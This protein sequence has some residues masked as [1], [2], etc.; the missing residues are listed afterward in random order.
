MSIA[1]QDLEQIVFRLNDFGELVE[2]KDRDSTARVILT[3]LG[4]QS[5]EVIDSQILVASQAS[6]VIGYLESKW[7]GRERQIE[8]SLESAKASVARTF[9]ETQKT[10][11]AKTTEAQVTEYLAG[12]PNIIDIMHRSSNITEVADI[13]ESLRYA[14]KNRFDGL[15]ELSRNER[16]TSRTGG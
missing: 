12:D 8:V 1:V 15:L 5:P 11:G 13:M 14:I 10:A 9:R 3:L 4:P 6:A 16:Q 7:R 2:I